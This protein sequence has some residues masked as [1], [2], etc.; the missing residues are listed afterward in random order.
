MLFELL[1][2][3]REVIC[4]AIF[5]PPMLTYG[6][7]IKHIIEPH[8]ALVTLVVGGG[9]I[10]LLLGILRLMGT[11]CRNTAAGANFEILPRQLV[12]PTSQ[13]NSGGMDALTTSRVRR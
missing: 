13:H 9:I 12:A 8:G 10:L 2:R 4:L 1:L 3:F 11:T 5:I 6:W 7:F